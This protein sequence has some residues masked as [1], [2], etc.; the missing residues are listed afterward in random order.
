MPFDPRRA[1]SLFSGD[2]QQQQQ[3]YDPSGLTAKQTRELSNE[4]AL[5]DGP[6]H[7]D[8]CAHLNPGKRGTG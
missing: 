1:A 6:D 8:K 4:V 3:Y 7:R 2:G 5:A